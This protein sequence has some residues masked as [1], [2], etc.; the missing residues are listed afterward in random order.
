MT[1]TITLRV[2]GMSCEACVKHVTE[3]LMRLEGVESAVV[4]LRNKSAQVVYDPERVQLQQLLE[5]V[6]E[7]GYEAFADG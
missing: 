7:E 2:G 1:K 4:N 5:A 6:E 3:A